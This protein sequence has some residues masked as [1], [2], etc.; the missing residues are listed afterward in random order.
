MSVCPHLSQSPPRAQRGRTL[1]ALSSDPLPP[2]PELSS[3]A[4]YFGL[5]SAFISFLATSNACSTYTPPPY[6]RR[7]PLHPSSFISRISF[8]RRSPSIPSHRRDSV[9]KLTRVVG[10]RIRNYDLSRRRDYL[11][12]RRLWNLGS[13]SVFVAYVQPHLQPHCDVLSRDFLTKFITKSDK[14][15]RSNVDIF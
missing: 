10:Q 4:N 14:A 6:R 13:R 15:S 2:L 7:G 1:R 3:R 12:S 11:L 8:P 5:S 9:E